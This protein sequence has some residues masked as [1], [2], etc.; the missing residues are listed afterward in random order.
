MSVKKF[1]YLGQ[2]I[3]G[4]RRSAFPRTVHA[5][6][7]RVS[8]D[9]VAVSNN[10]HSHSCPQAILKVQPPNLLELQGLLRAQAYIF[11]PYLAWPFLDNF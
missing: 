8:A 5:E 2:I 11:Y 6:R 9:A 4:L 10:H 3:L 1:S 7:D